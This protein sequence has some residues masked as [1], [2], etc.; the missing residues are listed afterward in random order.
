LD[1]TMTM[2]TKVALIGLDNSGQRMPT[3]MPRHQNFGSAGVFA[4]GV[5]L[6]LPQG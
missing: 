2:T 4:I 1:K 5:V 6:P 3:H